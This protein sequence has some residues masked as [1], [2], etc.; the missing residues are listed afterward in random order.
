MLALIIVISLKRTW[1][2]R[3]FLRTTSQN[4]LWRQTIRH[5]IYEVNV[6]K[7]NYFKTSFSFLNKFRP[8]KGGIETITPVKGFTPEIGPKQFWIE[9]Y[10]GKWRR[11]EAPIDNAL[12]SFVKFW[13]VLSDAIFN[14]LRKYTTCLECIFKN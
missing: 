6:L 7:Q 4:F 2:L 3:I 10:F 14:E 13:F 12:L 5:T 11:W 9:K 8:E 1:Q